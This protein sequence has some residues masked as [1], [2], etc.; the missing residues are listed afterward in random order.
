MCINRLLRICVF[1]S[2]KGCILVVFLKVKN[3][4]VFD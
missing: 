3:I 4:K 1:L 2:N